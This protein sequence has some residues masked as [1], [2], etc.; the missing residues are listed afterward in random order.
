[1]TS[2]QVTKENIT[3]ENKDM[4]SEDYIRVEEETATEEDWELV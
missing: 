3:K 4:S 2:E 1:V